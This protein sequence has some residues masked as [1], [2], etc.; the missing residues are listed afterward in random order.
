MESV[1]NEKQKE[2]DYVR[3]ESLAE[4]DGI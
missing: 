3:D 1:K 4:T 2:N